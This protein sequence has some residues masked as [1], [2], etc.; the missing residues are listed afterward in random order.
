MAYLG[1]ACPWP[2]Q[3]LNQIWIYFP[4]K[5][6]QGWY[7]GLMMTSKTQAISTFF[8]TNLGLV[9][10]Y[11]WFQV[12]AAETGPVSVNRGIWWPE[13]CSLIRKAN[14]LPKAVESSIFTWFFRPSDCVHYPIKTVGYGPPILASARN[15]LEMQNHRHYPRPTDSESA[16]LTRLPGDTYAHQI[17]RTGVHHID[18]SWHIFTLWVWLWCKC[19]CLITSMRR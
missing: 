10:F 15:L 16:F 12:A 14:A 19:I 2:L 9:A 5:A 13:Q 17:L 6:V 8:S 4:Y 7:S 1:A 11:S 18:H 3:L